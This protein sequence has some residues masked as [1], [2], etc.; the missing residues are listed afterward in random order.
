[1]AELINEEI[2][3]NGPRFN[4]VRKIYKMEDGKEFLRDL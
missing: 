1:M 3:F 2:K 4:V